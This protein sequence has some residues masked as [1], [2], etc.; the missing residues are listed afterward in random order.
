MAASNI[1]GQTLHTAFKFKF[2]NDYKSLSDK[3][4]DLQR[5]YFKN[6]EVIIIDEIS[7]MKSCQLYHLHLRLCELKQNER[8]MGGVCVIM[9]GKF[10][11]QMAIITLSIIQ[12]FQEI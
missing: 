5:D 8:V 4:R 2:G 9:F 3:N 7:M 11:I 6:V 1:E 12:Y 10:N